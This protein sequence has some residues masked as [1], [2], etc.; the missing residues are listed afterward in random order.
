MNASKHPAP[1]A[2]EG[3]RVPPTTY[4]ALIRLWHLR[5]IRTAKD[6]A[7]AQ[8]VIDALAVLDRRTRD[9]ED[10]LD[11][12]TGLF[13]AYENDHVASELARRPINTEDLS[14]LDMLRHLVEE[15]GMNAS[16][17]GRLLGHRR[18]GS[19][20]LR[21]ERG[22]SK[23]HIRIL[24]GHFHVGPELFLAAATGETASHVARPKTRTRQAHGR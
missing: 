21:G 10:Y 20:I 15:S 19:A 22:L 17:L 5:P 2:G 24:A 3:L 11:V 7:K 1:P 23:T 12:L 8:R 4:D 18:L 9:Q 13:E 6:F 16:D 14:P